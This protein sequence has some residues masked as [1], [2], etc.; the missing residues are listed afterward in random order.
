[1]RCVISKGPIIATTSS[2]FRFDPRTKII[3]A[4]ALSVAAF[5]A[6]PLILTLISLLIAALM[7][8]G[9][10]SSR[11]L[12]RA[13]KPALPFVLI[14]FLLHLLFSPGPPLLHL[15]LGPINVGTYGLIRGGILSW[16]LATLLL[17][18]SLLTVTTQPMDLTRGMEKLLRP[19]SIMRISPHDIALM[20]SLALRFIP[21]I[22]REAAVLRDA[23]SARGANLDAG[24]P[25]RRLFAVSY[26]AVPLCL[27]VF[28]RCDD[29]ITAMEARGYDGGPRSGL[30]QMALA[31]HD[32]VVIAT[33]LLGLI[34][35]LL[36]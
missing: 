2:V 9:R 3:V 36:I 31:P 21:T 14:V 5:R 10:V 28:R 1:M 13:C 30:R 18:G 19:I 23:Q 8:F 11:A 22:Q 34:A 29:L 12:Y 4:S 6:E 16:R 32:T 26:L 24:N 35:I 7:L 15:S 17:V 27:A 20:L 25:V 33:A